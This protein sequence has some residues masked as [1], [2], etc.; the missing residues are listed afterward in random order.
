M[1][2]SRLRVVNS[3]PLPFPPLE[4]IKDQPGGI[5]PRDF[6]AVSPSGNYDADCQTGARLAHAYITLLCEGKGGWAILMSAVQDMIAK[7]DNNGLVVGFM[8][9]ISRALAA[10][11]LSVPAIAAAVAEE[12]RRIGQHLA[13]LPGGDDGHH[14]LKVMK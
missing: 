4:F 12:D 3:K 10:S 5:H 6:W 1:A 9:V 7:N 14:A 2:K 11:L 13:S 8:G